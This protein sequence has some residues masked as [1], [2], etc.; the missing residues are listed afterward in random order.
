MLPTPPHLTHTPP[1][2][3]TPAANKALVHDLDLQVRAAGLSGI[4]LLGNGGSVSDPNTPDRCA[5]RA[6][7]GG[8]LKH[9]PGEEAQGGVQGAWS[10]Q[11]QRVI[12][13]PAPC[14]ASL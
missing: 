2:P 10:R 8:W 1:Q 7:A 4:P 9:G 3:P 5:R 14:L 6:W 12:R 13:L 11:R